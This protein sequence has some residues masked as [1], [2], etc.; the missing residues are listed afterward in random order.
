MLERRLNGTIAFPGEL[1][2]I[3]FILM[4]KGVYSGTESQLAV[5]GD[6]L[7]GRCGER[8][9]RPLNIVKFQESCSKFSH[10]AGE[11]ATVFFVIILF[12]SK[13]SWSIG[14]LPRLPS[15]KCLATSMAVSPC[16]RNALLLSLVACGLLDKE[17]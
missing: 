9:S 7:M 10:V 16:T 5:S 8:V 3:V 2:L 6:M 15:G 12:F 13:N 17:A 4:K 11:L 1:G 14:Q